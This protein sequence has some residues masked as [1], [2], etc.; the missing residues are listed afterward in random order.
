MVMRCFASTL[1]FLL[2]SSPAL[3]GAACAV[4]DPS[5]PGLLAAPT[6]DDDSS[7]PSMDVNGTRLHV[8][9]HGPNGAP[10]IV[11]LH[12]GPGGDFRYMLPMAAP[13]ADGAL[14]ADHR[15]VFWDQRGTGL[16]RRHPAKEVT[17]DLYQADLDALI[18]AVSPGTP[19]VLIGHSW[20]GTYAAAYL[21]RHPD[22]VRG[23]VLIDPQAIDHALYVAHGAAL[24]AEPF[25]EWLNDPLWARE[26]IS[27]EDHAR[28]DFLLASLQF[29]RIPRLGTHGTTPLFRPGAVV[30][31]YLDY[32]W[33]DDHDYDFGAGLRDFPRPVWILAGTDDQVLGYEFQR[34][35]QQLFRAATLI[36]LAG[37]GHNDPV[38][39]SAP[40]T[41]SLVRQYLD[42]IARLP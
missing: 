12:G 5:D 4:H 42:T 6:V 9:V 20:G 41:I 30:F 27:P 33:F 2:A 22:R 10:T 34:Q 38:M 39:G 32:S 1:T 17:M 40:R 16:S 23:A 36:P 21:G 7:L 37:D 15:L 35:Q 19:V 25:A 29:Y 28:A 13:D 8:E 31:K 14:V 11:L 18:D 24:D 26:I 3:L